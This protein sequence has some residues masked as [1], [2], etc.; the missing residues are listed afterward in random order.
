MLKKLHKFLLISYLG[1]FIMTFFIALF[2]ILMQFL[3]KYVDDLVGKGLEWQVILQLLFYA[4]ATFVPLALPLAILLSSLMTF[5]NMGEHFELVAL[6]SSGIS[7]QKFM[8]PLIILVLFICML[9]F[10]FSNNVLPYAN[11]KMGAL[12]YDVREQKPALNIKEGVFYKGIENYVIKVGK[13]DKDGV[14]IHNIMIYDHTQR[15]GNVNLTYAKSGRMETTEDKKYL[16]F[17]LYEGYNLSEKVDMRKFEV[18]RPLQ[19]IYFDE[20]IRKFDLSSFAMTRTSEDFFKDNYQML[21][22]KQ[23]QNSIDS[24]NLQLRDRYLDFFNSLTKRYFYLSNYDVHPDSMPD[25]Q[26]TQEQT[27]ELKPAIT[28]NSDIQNHTRPPSFMKHIINESIDAVKENENENIS[29]TSAHLST[30]DNLDNILSIFSKDEQRR[31]IEASLDGARSNK[32]YTYY[33]SEDL[34]GRQR[35]IFRHEIE[36]HRKFTLSIA[37][38]LLFFIGAPLG[39]IIRK[40]G[41]GLPV[42]ISVLFFVIYHV[43]SITGEK[44]VRTGVIPAYEGMWL[45]SMVLLPIGVF[46]VV[47]ATSDSPLFDMDTYIK[48]F[49]RINSIFGKKPKMATK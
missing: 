11:L 10:Y 38:L 19:R 9:A 6:K 46:F 30:L 25:E 5:G 28:Q 2:I 35:V 26:Q 45:A 39:A 29:N 44:F 49:R 32:D 47:K 23:L 21:N 14:G 15:Q 34:W 20:Q 48:I 40:G 4:S 17:T 18:T 43:I 12:L 27:Q 33:A 1:P 16:V 42:V 13:K 24:L 41:F 8:R 3:W 36:W 37:C 22:L 7:L 31:I